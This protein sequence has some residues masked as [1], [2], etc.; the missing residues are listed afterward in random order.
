MIPQMRSVEVQ[1]KV[2]IHFCNSRRFACLA[3][4]MFLGCGAACGETMFEAACAQR[5]G[6]GFCCATAF[7]A[8]NQV[9]RRPPCKSP[10][11]VRPSETILTHCSKLP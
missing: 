7:V 4:L 2:P 8:T 5:C 1:N 10:A 9:E 3:K 11:T 6:D